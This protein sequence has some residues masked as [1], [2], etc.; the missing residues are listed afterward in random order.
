MRKALAPE[1]NES[2]LTEVEPLAAFYRA[3]EYH[4][5]YYSR[6]SG[7]PY[8]RL[9]IAPKLAKF[10]KEHLARLKRTYI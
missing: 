10:R 5:E 3:E 7:Q 2:R 9:V 6:N 1:R 4:Q 8:C